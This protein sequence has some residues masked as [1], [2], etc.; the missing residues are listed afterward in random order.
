ML[1]AANNALRVSLLVVAA[2]ALP[3]VA[4]AADFKLF[5]HWPSV[6]ANL[7]IFLLLIYPVNRLLIQ[8]LLHLI[9]ERE[10]RTTGALERA[11]ELETATRQTGAQIE[12]RL[13][14]ARG[15]AQ[16]RRTAI[17]AE[18]EAE[19]RALLQSASNDA[20]QSFEAVRNAVAAELADART[21]LGADARTLAREAASRL[22]GRAI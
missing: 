22:L 11:T 10:A 12:A 3:E 18:A 5:P 8:P 16:A 7:L 21:A 9:E 19:E 2:S 14:E 6:A 1:A 13:G 17:L 20:A 15:R 4:S